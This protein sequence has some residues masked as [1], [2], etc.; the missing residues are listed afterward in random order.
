MNDKIIIIIIIT[1]IKLRIN[2]DSYSIHTKKSKQSSVTPP[3]LHYNTECV[4]HYEGLMLHFSRH[5]GVVP[6]HD[7]YNQQ[8]QHDIA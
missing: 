3:I 1:V 4:G 2:K 6:I 7:I 8:W 5:N